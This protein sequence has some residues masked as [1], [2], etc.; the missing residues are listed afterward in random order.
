MTH[1][2][3]SD[4]SGINLE[5]MDYWTPAYTLYFHCLPVTKLQHNDK[6]EMVTLSKELLKMFNLVHLKIF[7]F[8]F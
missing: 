3:I 1:T 7:F 6:N 2:N 4:I 5:Y 8:F